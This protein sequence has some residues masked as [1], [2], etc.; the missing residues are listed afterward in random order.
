MNGM[1]KMALQGSR[2]R[3]AIRILSK[4]PHLTPSPPRSLCGS[5]VRGLLALSFLLF[6]LASLFAEMDGPTAKFTIARLKYSGGGDWYNDPS[7]IPNMLDFLREHTAMAVASDEVPVAIPDEDLFSYP[8]IYMTGHGNVSFSEEEVQRLRVYLT[9][10][11]FLY[12]DDD[13]GMDAAF[14]RE[15]K[16]VFPNLELL[17]IPH[18]HGLFHHPF[19][20]P[21]GL[22]KIHQ[23]DGDSPQAFGIFHEKR[24]VVLYTYQ[25]NIS[26][27]WASSEVHQDP[28]E[29]RQAALE[30]GANIVVWALT[31]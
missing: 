17:E 27:G 9:H 3:R 14:R 7:V 23:H 19:E 26:D 5:V 24:L 16:K 18:T 21:Q 15:I 30:M 31:H 4:R 20:F 1:A 2:A 6:P 29:V 8:M 11:G 10:G 25:T 13:Y 22:P 28:P 12:A